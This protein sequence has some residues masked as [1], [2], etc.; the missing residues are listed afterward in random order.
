M[1]KPK[2]TLDTLVGGHKNTE[3]IIDISNKQSKT[4][5]RQ[6]K[7]SLLLTITSLIIGFVSL[8]PILFGDNNDISEKLNILIEKEELQ[9][10]VT[11]E[12]SDNL[13]SLQKKVKYLEENIEEITQNITE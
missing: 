5:N 10:K 11:Q 13:D 3:K 8:Y 6:F 12:M 4:A 9:S 1:N 7:L 2:T